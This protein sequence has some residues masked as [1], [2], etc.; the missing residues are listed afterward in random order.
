MPRTNYTVKTYD[1]QTGRIMSISP[2]W[3]KGNWE[4]AAERGRNRIG[5]GDRYVDVFFAVQRDRDV[6]VSR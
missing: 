5:M 6:Q 4:R 2:G 3:A 1:A